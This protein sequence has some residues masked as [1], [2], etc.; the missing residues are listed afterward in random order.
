MNKIVL[1]ML[2]G[3]AALLTQSC[4]FFADF[5][6][7]RKDL[8]KETSKPNPVQ[9]NNAAQAQNT[10]EVDNEEEF[11]DLEQEVAPTEEIAGLIPATNPDTRVRSI[12]RGRQDP[13]STVTL[14]PRIEIEQE[15]VKS[16]AKQAVNSNRDSFN[17]RNNDDK[18]PEAP[19]AEVFEPKLA[20]D[21]VISGLYEAGGRTRLIV[22]A[23]EE[24]NSRY[25]EVGQYLSNGQVLVKS[26]DHNHFPTPMVTLEQSGVEVI[27]TIGETAEDSAKGS[28]VSSLPSNSDR[29]TVLLSSIDAK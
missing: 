20:Q 27:K 10:T 1:L 26:I 25:V 29:N 7:A 24:N 16:K 22:Q 28:S 19:I 15:E 21:V 3:A 6:D 2:T 23:P 12:V 13:F 9:V 18:L 17:N 5:A 11:A 14:T 4:S 8:E